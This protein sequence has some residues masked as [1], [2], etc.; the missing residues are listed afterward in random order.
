MPP[1][2]GGGGAGGWGGGTQGGG[3]R[4]PAARERQGNEEIRKFLN[5]YKRRNSLCVDLYLQAFFQ[6][7]PSYDDLAEFVYSV[8]SVGGASPPHV[9][10]AA[11]LDIQLHPVKKLLFIKFTDQQIRDEVVVRL[12]AGLH[13]PAFDATVSGWGMDKPMERIRVLGTSP[14]TDE[15]ELRKILGQYGE[16]LEA[17]KGLISK[18]LPGCTNGI[19][20]VKMFIGEGKSLPPFLIMKDDGEVWQLATGEASVCWKCGQQGHIGDKCRQAVH[21]LAESLASAALGVQPSWAHVVKGGVSV[22]PTPPP[23]PPRPQVRQQLISVQLSSVILRNGR[24]CLKSVKFPIFNSSVKV[25]KVVEGSVSKSDENVAKKAPEHSY[26]MPATDN[27]IDVSEEV[28]T[29]QGGTSASNVDTYHQKK[30]KLSSDLKITGD[31]DQLSTSPDLHHK[32][33]AGSSQHLQ[34]EVSTDDSGGG[35]VHTNMFGINFVMWFDISIEGKSSMDPQ[36]N[37]WGGRVEFGFSDKTFPKD[38]E[39]YFLMF[40]D[41]CSTQSHTCAGRVMGVLFDKRDKVLKPPIYDPRNVVDLIDKYRDAHIMDSGW[42]E[43]D[44]EEWVA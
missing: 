16:I 37:D 36:E 3:R 33:P 44:T 19:W 1:D 32:V 31:P 8:L 9:I 15:A 39:D 34:N 25:G 13:W 7:K 10:R 18:K 22:V 14:E 2:P 41:D 38:F 40:E 23:L 43:V 4:R 29:K 12:Q 35:G 24:D 20:T 27:A 30:A 11:V 17:Q 6:R 28:K 42:R 21:F 5:F 26:T